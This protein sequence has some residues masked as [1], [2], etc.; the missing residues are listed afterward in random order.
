[1]TCGAAFR[2]LEEFLRPPPPALGHRRHRKQPVDL[3]AITGVDAKH[4]PD[5]EIVPRSLDDPDIISRTYVALDDDSEVRPWPQCLGEA[6]RKHLVVHPHAKPPARNPRLGHLENRCS[7]LPT[8]SDERV[9]DLDPFRREIFAELT[10]SKR[11]TDVSFPPA[12]V[13]DRVR[14][15]CFV[16]S[17]VRSAIGLLVAG[18]IHTARY[19]D[20]TNEVEHDSAQTRSHLPCDTRV[21]AHACPQGDPGSGYGSEHGQLEVAVGPAVQERRAAHVDL[22]ANARRLEEHLDRDQP[23]PERNRDHMPRDKTVHTPF[24]FL[25]SVTFGRA[26]REEWTIRPRLIHRPCNGRACEQ[27]SAIRVDV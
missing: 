23:G 19:E 3:V 14:V 7:Y 21:P 17:P 2:L 15:H 1:R 16:G 8:L 10:V 5:G 22:A 20:V 24:S 9:V 18:E 11:A 4:V 27:A 26:E 13:L 12:R 6:A 25:W